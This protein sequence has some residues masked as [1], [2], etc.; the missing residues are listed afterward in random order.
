MS[1]Q[2]KVGSPLPT[3]FTFRYIDDSKTAAE[4]ASCK[5]PKILTLNQ[6]FLLGKRIV[7]IAVPAAFSP[8]CSEVHIPEVL[9]NLQRFKSKSVDMIL[10]VSNN[11][12]FVLHE[13]KR[14][15][16]GQW[17]KDILSK[18]QVIFASDCNTE[19][20]KAIGYVQDASKMGMGLRTLRYAVVVVD[21]IVRYAAQEPKPGVSVSGAPAVL[22]KLWMWVCVCG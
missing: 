11:D 1:Q 17:K 2:L 13:W 12:A 14:S 7:I 3:G 16:D 20:S 22:A 8:T 10:V 4:D 6:K 19:F 18:F 21:G 9:A 5:F 15:L